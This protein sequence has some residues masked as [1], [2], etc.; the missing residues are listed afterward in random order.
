MRKSWA[1]GLVILT[2]VWTLPVSAQVAVWIAGQ[3]MVTNEASIT[4]ETQNPNAAVP[5]WSYGR[6]SVPATTTFNL[7]TAGDHA[8][9]FGGYTGFDGFW[10]SSSNGPMLAVNSGVA[11]IVMNNG[12]GPLDAL[13]PGEIFLDPS[14]S[15]QTAVVRWT[16]PAAGDYTVY[17]YWRD[18]D[19][20]GGNGVAAYIVLNGSTIFNASL[21]NG[22][23]ASLGSPLVL[24]LAAGDLLDFAL[25]PAGDVTYDATAFNATIMAAIPEPSTLI[26]LLGGAGAALL[27]HRRR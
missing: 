20:Y 23:Q 15:G 25:N 5:E 12:P 6:R 9:N 13:A 11:P 16:A 4:T 17:A 14:F 8:N 10:V 1:T 3:D 26:L 2:A 27:W 7:T 18:L 21:S 22:G 19:P 24:N